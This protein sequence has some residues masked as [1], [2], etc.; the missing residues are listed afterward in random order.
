MSPRNKPFWNV[1][2]AD[3]LR[4]HYP[5]F[6]PDV[7]SCWKK[8]VSG[9]SDTDRGLVL[10]WDDCSKNPLSDGLSSFSSTGDTWPSLAPGLED[11][12][13]ALSYGRVPYWKDLQ[14]Y[15]LLPRAESPCYTWRWYAWSICDGG[16]MYAEP[17]LQL[18]SPR[19]CRKTDKWYLCPQGWIQSSL[20]S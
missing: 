12:E 19:L 1:P 14:P 20:W 8:N 5:P 11:V 10:S 15:V 16:G 13:M 9:S 17:E 18:E 6:S 7:S 2:W 4:S 3:L